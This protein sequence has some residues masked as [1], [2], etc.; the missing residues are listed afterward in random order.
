MVIFQEEP[1]EQLLKD[2]VTKFKANKA[3]QRLKTL[4]SHPHEDLHKYKGSSARKSFGQEAQSK[5]S[6]ENR[7][8]V[9]SILH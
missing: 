9:R 3:Y 7:F 4:Q 5:S 1:L 6:S 2:V 8:K